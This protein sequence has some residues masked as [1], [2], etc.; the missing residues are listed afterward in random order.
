MHYADPVAHCGIAVPV[1]VLSSVRRDHHSAGLPP[2]L[3]RPAAGCPIRQKAAG[4]RRP[5][6]APRY[7]FGPNS[8]CNR[9]L[10]TTV[11]LSLSEIGPTAMAIPVVIFGH[12]FTASSVH[13]ADW[14]VPLLCDA[15]R[16]EV[17]FCLCRNRSLPACVPRP[18][19]AIRQHSEPC[20]GVRKRESRRQCRGRHLGS[21]NPLWAAA[22]RALS[23]FEG[24]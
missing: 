1:Q 5:G 10:S 21:F 16:L 2:S 6:V 13:S 17:K 3:R 9:M 23:D 11:D 4:P 24:L 20:R 7:R 14:V 19:H 8:M 12:N 22:R 18:T 15:E